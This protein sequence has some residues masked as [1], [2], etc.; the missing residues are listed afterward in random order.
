M[1]AI[2][3]PDCRDILLLSARRQSRRAD[4]KRYSRKRE[5]ASNKL[6]KL[7][8]NQKLAIS[9]YEVSNKIIFLNWLSLQKEIN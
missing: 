5:K 3:S 9:S 4:N 2:F 1:S 7:G 8:V 6:R